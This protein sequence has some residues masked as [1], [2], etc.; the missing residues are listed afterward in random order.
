MSDGN[1][2]L[3]TIDLL[4]GA[5]GW[6][7]AA[8]GLPI[9]IVMTIDLWDAC[10][11]TYKLNHPQTR[12]MCGDVRSRAFRLQI[13][14]ECAGK[15]NVVLGA[16]PCEWLSVRRNIGQK[17][18]VTKK[19]YQQE[20]E[21]LSAVLEL[22]DDLNPEYWCLEDVKGLAAELPPHVPWLEIDSQHH[23]AQRRK[24][25]YVGRFPAPIF[26]SNSLTL[27]DKLRPGPYRIGKRAVNRKI[28]KSQAFAPDRIIGAYP[29]RKSPTVCTWNSRRDAEVVIVDDSIPGGRRQIEWQ[30]AASLQGFPEDYVFYGSPSDAWKMIAQAIQID[31]GRAILKAI[32]KDWCAKRPRVPVAG[33]YSTAREATEPKGGG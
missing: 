20:K 5:G 22:I 10:C 21:T 24:R 13:A 26:N 7:C 32:V 16:I 33:C 31:T 3:L 23:S 4:G 18:K 12:V 30:E 8:R 6:A 15:I 29:D 17:N 2:E 19:E 11:R 27:G 14:A 25:I 9:Q 28:V 1:M